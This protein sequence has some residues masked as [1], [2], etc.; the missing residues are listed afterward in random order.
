MKSYCL[1]LLLF[2]ISGCATWKKALISEGNKNEAV[3]NAIIDFLHC[4][5]SINR[6]SVFSITI[7]NIGDTILGVSISGVSNK[8]S[9]ITKNEQEYSYQAFPTKYY[10]QNSKLFYWKDST[11]KVPVEL[12]SKLSKMNKIDTAIIGTYF[13]DRV[14][15][16]SQK[17]MD[18][19]FCKFNLSK[20][21]KVYT[22]TAMGWYKPPKVN[23]K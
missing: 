10:E 4:N 17:A 9:V 22:S 12:I 19:Y 8:I 5:K 13:P 11:E 20:Y 18:Y 6:D 1:L 2:F 7:K 3:K 16:E 23:C 21:K 15:D 14:I